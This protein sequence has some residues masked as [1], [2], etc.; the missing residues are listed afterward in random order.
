MRALDGMTI[1]LDKSGTILQGFS[2]ERGIIKIKDVHGTAMVWYR[3]AS[4]STIPIHQ[5]L[6]PH[7]FP[8]NWSGGAMNPGYAPTNLGFSPMPNSSN[9]NYPSAPPSY[10]QINARELK[11]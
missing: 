4:P 9:Q 7:E 1:Y 11:D 10:E 2:P 3:Q 6:S 8:H 5:S